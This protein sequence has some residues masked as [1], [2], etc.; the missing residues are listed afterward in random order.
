MPA[1][2][3][4]IFIFLFSMFFFSFFFSYMSPC[5]VFLPSHACKRSV[6]LHLCRRSKMCLCF[7]V[8]LTSKKLP[9]QRS[10]RLPRH[11]QIGQSANDGNGAR[12]PL[13]RSSS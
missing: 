3:L 12:A 7:S 9:S 13:G 8:S 2:L 11:Q 6:E 5:I 10:H 1:W 4:D